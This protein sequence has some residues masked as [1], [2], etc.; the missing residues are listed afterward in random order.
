MT[1]YF[2]Y[3]NLVKLR[4][5]YLTLNLPESKTMYHTVRYAVFVLYLYGAYLA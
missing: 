3:F 5:E 1:F 4:I 2:S